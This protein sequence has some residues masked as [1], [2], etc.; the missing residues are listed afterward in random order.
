MSTDA[1]VQ[2][3]QKLAISS[4]IV[5]L[6]ELQVKHEAIG[7]V[8]GKGLL[9]GIEL[10]KDRKTKEPLEEQIVTSI[11]GHCLQNKVMIGRT[12]RSFEKYNNVLLFSPAFISTKGDID[13]IIEAVDN[14][15]TEQL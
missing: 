12:N 2:D 13:L 9:S 15:L 8:R 11:A 10:V 6:F 3:V 14:A 1:I 4:G 7:D 5:E